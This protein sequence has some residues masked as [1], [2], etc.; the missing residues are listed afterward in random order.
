MEPSRKAALWVLW[1][2]SRAI[3]GVSLASAGWPMNRKV[4]WMRC[5]EMTLRKGDCSSCTVSPW[6]SVPSKTTSPVVF[7]K[8]A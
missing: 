5:S 1:Q 3:A 8:S 7:V 4:C 2:V 6:R